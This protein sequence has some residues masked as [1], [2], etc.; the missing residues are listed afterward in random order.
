MREQ[1]VIGLQAHTRHRAMTWLAALA[2]AWAML[3]GSAIAHPHVFIEVQPTLIFAKGGIVGIQ[4][5]WMFDEL[6]SAA[7]VR[8]FDVDR[9]RKF[10]TAELERLKM[11]AFDNLQ[12][13]G[14]FTHFR[15]NGQMEIPQSVQDF[16]AFIE[17]G[18]LVY[19]FV[20][21]PPRLVDPR[22]VSYGLLFYDETYYVD[23]RLAEGKPVVISGAQECRAEVEK[24]PDLPDYGGMFLPELVHVRCS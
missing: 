14:Y 20:V 10:N 13:F 24:N 8:D 4:V 16:T 2:G 3:S 17:K 5:D 22:R 1:R 12:S 18:R 21:R 11:G 19:R 23:L 9:D 6:F 7:V 15:W